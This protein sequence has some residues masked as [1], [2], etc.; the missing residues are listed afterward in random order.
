VASAGNIGSQALAGMA[1]TVDYANRRVRI[2][3]SRR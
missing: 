3:P 1:V 2:V